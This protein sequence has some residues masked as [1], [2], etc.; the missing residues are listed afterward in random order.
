MALP[1]YRV[2]LYL[3][4][5]IH[6][7]VSDIDA[8]SRRVASVG[9]WATSGVVTIV[10]VCQDERVAGSLALTANFDN[11]EEALQWAYDLIGRVLVEAKDVEVA[12]VLLWQTLEPSQDWNRISQA[13]FRTK[14]D[15]IQ[16]HRDALSAHVDISMLETRLNALR[17]ARNVL[18]H[19]TL[20][21]RSVG[22]LD[23]DEFQFDPTYIG[24]IDG[25]DLYEFSADDL[26]ALSS[27][28][29]ELSTQV[30]TLVSSIRGSK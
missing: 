9:Q 14:I 8:T 3:K 23:G 29:Q 5:P 26:R 28:A 20:A 30:R 7:T 4:G 11:E 27:D 10:A 19:G 6:A 1:V 22:D 18:A 15:V 13:G 17:T 16:R 2:Q 12:L 24:V 21:G 25:P